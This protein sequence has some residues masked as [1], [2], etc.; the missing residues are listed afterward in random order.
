MGKKFFA[1]MIVAIMLL[2]IFAGCSQK[3]DSEDK[4]SGENSSAEDNSSGSESSG[5]SQQDSSQKSGEFTLYTYYAESG[6]VGTDYAIEELKKLYPDVTINIEHRT[7][8]DGAV[9]KTRAAVGELPDIFEC[10]GTLTDIFIESKDIV[11]LDDTM[12]KMGYFDMFVE[13]TFSGKKSED[14]HYYA[15]SV[16]VREPALFF[17]NKKVCCF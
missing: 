15:V 17:Y 9:L 2:S 1:I 3:P 16:D 5:D 7:D 14:G 12:E 10:T 8:S 4:S 11:P 13:N 6:K